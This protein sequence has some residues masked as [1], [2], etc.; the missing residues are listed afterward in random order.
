MSETRLTARCRCVLGL[1]GSKRGWIGVRLDLDQTVAP[2]ARFHRNINEA[3][4]APDRP[5][6][7]T[8]RSATL[9]QH[10]RD[11]HPELAFTVVKMEIVI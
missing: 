1:D 8:C 9:Q 6:V 4:A 3:L 10:V 11:S 5:A 7:S 2:A